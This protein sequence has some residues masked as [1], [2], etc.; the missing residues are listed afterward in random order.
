M[1]MFVSI[2]SVCHLQDMRTEFG[3]IMMD[4][5]IIGCLLACLLSSEAES[6]L[7]T[8]DTSK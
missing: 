3:N 7:F 5:S 2:T 6:E 4:G 1:S 8:V